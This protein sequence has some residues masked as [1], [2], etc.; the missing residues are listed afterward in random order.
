MNTSVLLLVSFNDNRDM[1]MAYGEYDI[2]NY[3]CMYMSFFFYS[4]LV[5]LTTVHFTTILTL[6]QRLPRGE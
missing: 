5:L 3:I 2:I 4:C 1:H 6:T